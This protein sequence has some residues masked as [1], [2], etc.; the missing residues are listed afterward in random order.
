MNELTVANRGIKDITEEII[1]IRTSAQNMALMYACEIGRRLTEA[2]S[3]LSHGEWMPWLEEKVQFSQSSANRFM[4]L[5]REY[6]ERVSELFS[7]SSTLANLSVSNALSLLA[8]PENERESFVEEH[9]AEH[10]STEE[11]KQLIRERDEALE[12]KK[13]AEELQDEAERERAE[14]ERQK[15]ALSEKL[16]EARFELEA[17]KSDMEELEKANIALL[18]ENAELKNRPIEVAVERDEESIKKAAEEA[19]KETEK[20]WAEK[21]ENA[22]SELKKEHA[23]ALDEIEQEKKELSEKLDEAQKMLDATEDTE[24]LEEKIRELE[25]KLA[26]SDKTVA[27]FGVHFEAIQKSWEQLIKLLKE[28]DG[29]TQTKMH[30]ALEA[31]T[32]K[33][34]EEI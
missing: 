28:M 1:Y 7:N 13:H 4:R 23:E 33:M 17:G 14:A 21:L 29:E 15:K 20:E 6:G 16:D 2:K 34:T 26:L 24:E 5:Y 8:L 27:V 25:K 19:K 11:F 30:K 3:L 12:A 22:T 10:L 18:E 32:R 9:D 31:L